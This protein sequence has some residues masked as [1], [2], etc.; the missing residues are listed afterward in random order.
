LLEGQGERKI[1]PNM[2]V[3]DS[4]VLKN[5]GLRPPAY[6]KENRLQE[7]IKLYYHIVKWYSEYLETQNAKDILK[8]F[9]SIYPD[10]KLTPVKKIDF[11]LW[12]I[13]QKPAKPAP[14]IKITQQ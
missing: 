10:V 7:T 4:T 13:R 8:L 2:P 6:Y 14:V 3:W 11:V 5:L 9:D 1:D 12:S